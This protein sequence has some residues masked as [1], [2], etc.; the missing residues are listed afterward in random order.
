VIIEGGGVTDLLA[1]FMGAPVT[2]G[3][4]IAVLVL[5]TFFLMVFLD[6]RDNKSGGGND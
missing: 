5:Y 3:T 2:N 4:L 1:D 6:P